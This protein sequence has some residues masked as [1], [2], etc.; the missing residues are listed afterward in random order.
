LRCLGRRK[1]A[2]SDI[3]AFISRWAE[4]PLHP[5]RIFHICQGS[6]IAG[7][8]AKKCTA[9]AESGCVCSLDSFGRSPKEKKKTMAV[10]RCCAPCSYI[11]TPPYSNTSNSDADDFF[12]LHGRRA[13]PRNLAKG[14]RLRPDRMR[15]LGA[16]RAPDQFTIA[17]FGSLLQAETS[18]SRSVDP[19]AWHVPTYRQHDYFRLANMAGARCGE[20]QLHGACSPVCTIFLR[21][22][23]EAYRHGSRRML[24]EASS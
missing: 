12:N 14:K 23:S 7:Q 6:G 3:C 13:L 20:L 16:H 18:W 2:T 4:S 24:F 9:E 19:V 15:P 8:S 11:L 21:L 17:P 1:L 10:E 5:K 22:F